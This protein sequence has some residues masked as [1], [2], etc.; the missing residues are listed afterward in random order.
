[1]GGISWTTESLR[2]F[3]G[4]ESMA[5]ELERHLPADLLDRFQIHPNQVMPPES[6]KIQ[7]LWSHLTHRA[8]E[9]DF[10]LADGGWRRFHR[11]VFVSNWQAQWFIE[12]YEIPW[13]QCAVMHNA[14]EPVPV[15]D[16]RFEPIPVDRPIRL[17]YTSSPNRGLIILYYVFKAISAERDDVELDVYSAFQLYGRE[18]IDQEWEPLFDALREL[19]HV[20]YHGAVPNQELQHGL[21]ASD[22]FAYPSI[23]LETS[24]VS[25]ME[26]M[27]AGL[28]CVHP[29][30]A[31]LYETAA[32]WTAMYQWQ[33]DVT[34]HAAVFYQ[35]LTGVIDALRRGDRKLLSSRAAQKA[36]ADEHY[37]WDRRAEQWETFLRKIIS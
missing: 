12:K 19:P 26:A 5:R 6:G 34:R 16:S 33:D 15:A 36:Y 3:G 7:I 14:I 24:C 23:G 29:N 11:I 4:T 31:A 9:S 10:Y 17:I 2:S 18:E 21:V 25:L 20:N 30:Y 1:M 22:V 35:T 37:N 13:S 28:V 8:V 32:N 27:S